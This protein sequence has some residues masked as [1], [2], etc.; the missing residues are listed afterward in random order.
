[1]DKFN[2]I[3]TLQRLALCPHHFVCFLVFDRTHQDNKKQPIFLVQELTRGAN[4]LNFSHTGAMP[5]GGRVGCGLISSVAEP[6]N[7]VF[8]LGL[9]V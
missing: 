1:M 8:L 5:R 7:R 6:L 4:T 3:G 9:G 2:I